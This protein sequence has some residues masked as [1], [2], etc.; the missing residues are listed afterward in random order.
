MESSA[1]SAQDTLPLPPG[2]GLAASA[3]HLADLA[4]VG[5][6]E[7]LIGQMLER[8]GPVVRLGP[9]VVSSGLEANRLAL[10]SGPEKLRTFPNAEFPSLASMEGEEHVRHRRV[11]MDAFHGERL[12]QYVTA[13][14]RVLDRHLSRWSGVVE[15]FP[16]MST[17]AL[18]TLAE[19]MIGIP[20][21][22]DAYRRFEELYWPL[23]LREERTWLPWRQRARAREAKR[24]MWQI[25]AELIP[26]RRRAPGDD[27]LT[28]MIAASERTAERFIT[29]E[30][31]VR[32]AYMLLD[33]GQGDIAVY[34][35]YLIA[36][37]AH[38]PEALT[39]VLAERARF[40]D[41]AAYEMERE[42]P[43][44]AN[45]LREL[46]RLF[47]PVSEVHRMVEADVAFGGF[48][49]PKGS[50]FV[51]S[52]IH[53]HLSPRVFRAPERFDPRRFAAGREE[54]R[55]PYALIP[56]GAGRHMCVAAA[57]CRL[58]ACVV[59]HSLLE[60]YEPTWIDNSPLPPIDYRRT[61][62][63]PSRP[64]RI[65]LAPRSP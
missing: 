57:F 22:S 42:L 51:S 49:I 38:H 16:L 60:R 36:V 1:T 32:Y 59:L 55:T 17:L 34:L 62:Q 45:F 33:F 4:L 46:E 3:V 27:A 41:R 6:K 54:H 52:V 48:R 64:L 30:D 24:G 15:L 19:T 28:T 35:T 50:V 56:F 12:A 21:G 14:R 2:P 47:P 5:N 9:Y 29:D 39:D 20:A 63:V 65:R 61:L 7:R 58:H 8:H 37:A 13:M 44:T 43:A 40:S 31:L 26:Q 53:G 25:L 11:V 18:E 23:V 10:G